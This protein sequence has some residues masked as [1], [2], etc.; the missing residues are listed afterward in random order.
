MSKLVPEV[1]PA[2]PKKQTF[3]ECPR[4]SQP[5]EGFQIDEKA[6]NDCL[7]TLKPCGCTSHSTDG[8]YSQFVDVTK[9]SGSL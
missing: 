9:R 8:H 3:A 4:C 1:E 5:V 2:K 7:I 6:V